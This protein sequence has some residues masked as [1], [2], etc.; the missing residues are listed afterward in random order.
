MQ[1]LASIFI[2]LAVVFIKNFQWRSGVREVLCR[3]GTY[4]IL[5]CSLTSG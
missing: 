3:L 2:A 4:E 1:L 5:W